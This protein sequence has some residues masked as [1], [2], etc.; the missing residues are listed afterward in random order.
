MY[1]KDLIFLQKWLAQLGKVYTL[2]ELIDLKYLDLSNCNIKT[3]PKQIGQ[4]I[5][6][7]TL[8]L[9]NNQITS[10]PKEVDQLKSLKIVGMEEQYTWFYD[11]YR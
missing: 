5:N 7:T 11:R 4:L 10:L 6:L 8:Y 1:N 9:W 2:K 3:L